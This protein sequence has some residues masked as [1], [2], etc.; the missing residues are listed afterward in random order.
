MRTRTRPRLRPRCRRRRPGTP[1]VGRLRELRRYRARFAAARRGRDRAGAEELSAAAGDPRLEDARALPARPP[2]L[3]DRR[4]LAATL[5]RD[6]RE[7]ARE[8]R[9]R[10]GRAPRRRELPHSRPSACAPSPSRNG[11][12]CVRARRR[13]SRTGRVRMRGDGPSTRRNAAPAKRRASRTARRRAGS[14]GRVRGDTTRKARSRV[15]RRPHSAPERAGRA[16]HHCRPLLVTTLRKDA[17]GFLE[18]LR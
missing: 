7:R 6:R 4:P 15:V 9:R 8:S 11:R 12:T 18:C 16:R 17:I 10:A 14:A 1:S 3:Q 13:R 2:A 5:A